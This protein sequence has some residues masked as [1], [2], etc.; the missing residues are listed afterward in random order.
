MKLGAGGPLGGRGVYGRRG[1]SPARSCRPRVRPGR[2][3]LP[4]DCW[5]AEPGSGLGHTRSV[6]HV[7]NV[8]NR[9]KMGKRCSRLICGTV[10][11]RRASHVL[12]GCRGE[13]RT[14]PAPGRC[15]DRRGCTWEC[16][17][18]GSSP[19]RP[20][21]LRGVYTLGARPHHTLPAPTAPP[22]SPH[23]CSSEAQ[24]TLTLVYSVKFRLKPKKKPVAAAGN[25][26]QVNLGFLGFFSVSL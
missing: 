23:V 12:P 11:G 2:R 5:V 4:L 1:T 19:G 13:M 20:R 15:G 26:T 10:G 9:H 18:A 21:T 16:T 7:V 14:L 6:R 25:R 17:W 3:A 22:C 8:G 24:R